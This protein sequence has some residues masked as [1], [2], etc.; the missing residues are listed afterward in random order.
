MSHWQVI[1]VISAAAPEALVWC[2]VWRS[3]WDGADWINCDT[4]APVHL[5]V[6]V[7]ECVCAGLTNQSRLN[8][9]LMAD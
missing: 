5:S 6:L 8:T 7:C 3:R 4:R 2:G 9:G 1:S